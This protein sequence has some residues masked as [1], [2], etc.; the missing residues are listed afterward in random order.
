MADLFRQIRVLDPATG[1]DRRR[2]VRIQ[3][4]RLIAIADSLDTQPEDQVHNHPDWALGPALTDLYSRSGEPGAEPRETWQSLAAAAAAGGF[5][6]VL[7]LPEGE[8][9]LDQAEALTARPRQL[10]SV[11]LDYWA[12]YSQQGQGEQLSELAELATQGA[13][14]FGDGQPLASPAFLRQ[15]LLYSRSLN[16]PLLLWPCDRQLRGKGRA[17]QGSLALRWGLPVDP[18]SSET[19]A[20]ALLLELLADSPTPVHLMRISTARSVELIAQ[21]KQ[22][23]LPVTASVTWLHLLGNTADLSDYEPNLR[24]APPLPE[25]DEQAVLQQ[26][27]RDGLIEAIAVDHS[28]YLY[29]E[30]TVAFGEAPAGAIGLELAL[31]QLWQKLVVEAGWSPLTLWQR[32]STGPQHCIGET[33]RSLSEGD[34]V[35]VFDPQQSWT[36]SETSLRSQARNTHLLGQTLI[37]RVWQSA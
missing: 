15:L 12:A 9:W 8:P 23:G 24:L 26:A 3:G 4:G 28:P 20:L 13:I 21:A 10:G 29:E 37:G 22:R 27:V 34:R 16:R 2:D 33:P 7:L 32:L 31:P 19:A 5:G 36:V 11:Q 1:S 14:G 35:T 25:P 6:R 17:R 18:Q 30:K